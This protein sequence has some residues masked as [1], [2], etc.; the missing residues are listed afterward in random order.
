[1]FH[2]LALQKEDENSDLLHGNNE[3]LKRADIHKAVR[4][5]LGKNYVLPRCLLL[6]PLSVLL[7]IM[8]HSEK[9]PSHMSLAEATFA[10]LN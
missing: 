5:V 6:S 10:F 2:F 7:A 9:V 1:M 8:F 4:V 3:R